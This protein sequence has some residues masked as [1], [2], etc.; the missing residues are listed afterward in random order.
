MDRADLIRRLQA[1]VGEA[2]VLHRPDDLVVYEQDALMV[3]R[4][5]PDVVVLPDSAQQ[6]SN[7]V[8]AAR[9]AGLPVVARGAGTG[10]SG[11]A[12]PERGGVVVA[13]TRM[14]RIL[15]VD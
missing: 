8:Q 15:E 1:V 6:V 11:G 3:A 12:I 7:I 4:H 13:L 5:A 10:L 14:T 2:Y 9:E